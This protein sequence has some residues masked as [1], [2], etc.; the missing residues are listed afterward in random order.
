M[1]PVTGITVKIVRNFIES[2]KLKPCVSK[3]FLV[4]LAGITSCEEAPL[5][6]EQINL[7]FEGSPSL[8]D[9]FDLKVKSNS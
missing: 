3:V 8:R 1:G 2:R 4:R 7:I 6:D 9:A 5:S